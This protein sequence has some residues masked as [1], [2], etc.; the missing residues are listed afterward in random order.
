MEDIDACCDKKSAKLRTPTTGT[1][2]QFVLPPLTEEALVTLNEKKSLVFIMMF[3]LCR[4]KRTVK[5][6][7]WS[8]WTK[9]VFGLSL[10]KN[11]VIQKAVT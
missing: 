1:V 7:K 5:V 4:S 8:I 2:V 10:L 11:Q 9:R 3:L 6:V